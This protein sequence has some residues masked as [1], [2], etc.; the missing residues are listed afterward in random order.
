MDNLI[1]NK[2]AKPM[3]IAMENGSATKAGKAPQVL[4][5][6][7]GPRTASNNRTAFMQAFEDMVIKDL[8][9]MV[10]STYRTIPSQ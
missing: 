2:K 8:I 6:G 1:A 7:G 9:P 10:D 3:I 5:F 4:P